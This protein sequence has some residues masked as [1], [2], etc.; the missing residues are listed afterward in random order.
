[1]HARIDLRVHFFL[2]ERG[3]EMARVEGHQANSG[4]FEA[5]RELC[6]TVQATET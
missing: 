1:M 6:F 3:V 4:H 2:H 5:P